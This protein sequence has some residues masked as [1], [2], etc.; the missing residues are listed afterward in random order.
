MSETILV[1]FA[2]RFGSTEEVAEVIADVLRH[3]GM[4]VTVRPLSAVHNVG[5]YRAV[6]LGSAINHA[7]WLPEAV[8]FVRTHQ[9]H[10]NR[11]PLALFSVH[12]QNTGD[13]AESRAGRLAYLDEIRP[14]LEPVAEAYFAG[15]F[16]RQAATELL[17]G[18]LARAMPPLDFRKWDEIEAWA[19][20]VADLLEEAEVQPA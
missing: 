20:S 2:T 8:E 17:P 9:Y 12:I 18:W 15:R 16:N 11:V 3:E 19:E 13:D 5:D 7:N 10:L 6:V 1:T 4:E 14:W